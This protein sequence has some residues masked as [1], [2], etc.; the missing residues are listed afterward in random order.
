MVAPFTASKMFYLGGI[1]P[2]EFAYI[3]RRS[4]KLNYSPG[5]EAAGEDGEE[6]LL[7]LPPLPF[8]AA[9]YFG[10]ADGFAFS[11]FSAAAFFGAGAFLPFLPPLAPPLPDIPF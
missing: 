5:L 7:L 11:P 6:G 9:T 2:P 8:A 10:F 4:R 1:V 3:A